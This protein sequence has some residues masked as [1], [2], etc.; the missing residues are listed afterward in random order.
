MYH[1][2]QSVVH[3]TLCYDHLC[4]LTVLSTA[5][6][7]AS[8]AT[9]GLG[10]IVQYNF[11]ITP[12]SGSG[13]ASTDSINA[14]ITPSA[15]DPGCTLNGTAI[16]VNFTGANAALGRMVPD[17]ASITCTFSQTVTSADLT[18]TQLPAYNISATYQQN[19]GIAT[20]VPKLQFNRLSVAAVPP[21]TVTLR[22]PMV[23]VTNSPSNSFTADIQ[24]G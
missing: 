4:F 16:T 7:N 20:T 13:L 17:G 3:L 14:T 21:P 2:P 23:D 12:I 22:T 19:G 8:V 1:L 9:P 15:T 5:A 10:A 11:T 18:N 6:P 24:G